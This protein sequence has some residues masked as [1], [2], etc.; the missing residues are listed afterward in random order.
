MRKAPL[1][2]WA[3]F[4][5]ANSAFPTII[6]TFVFATYFSE[7]VAINKI[8]GSSQWGKA[9]GIASLF[10]AILSPILGAIA[11]NEGRRKPWLAFFSLL[12]I[13]ATA[14]LWYAKPDP[15]YTHYTLLMVIL[16]TIGMEVGMVFYNA[17]L[18]ELVPDKYVG[19]ASGWSWGLGYFGGLSALVVAL[20][21]FIDHGAAWFG[22][23]SSQAEHIRICGPLVAA[24]FLIFGWP[25]FAF[26]PDRPSTGL[27]I[28]GA[29]RAGLKSLY[30]T[31]KS[32]KQ[33]KEIAKFLLARILY[34]DGL[35]TIFAFGGIYAAGTFNM[36][37][38]EVIEF[39]IAMN[40]GA[41]L[42]AMLFGWL[43]DY[44]GSKPTVLISLVLMMI[45]GSGMLLAT[46]KTTFWILGMILSLCVGP[47]QSASRSIM[48]HLAPPEL[49]TELFGLYAFSGKATA[50]MGPWIFGFMTLAFNSQRI[51]MSSTMLFLLVGAVI[52]CFVKVD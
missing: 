52:L 8:I 21:V 51:G 19:R 22:L 41:G 16:G 39:G 2:A 42:G 12:C 1:F 27:G 36:S 43:D 24:W 9:I 26:T 23:S 32:L 5:W 17:M 44:K 3:I 34:I 28:Q 25:L 11:D 48:V 46:S 18:K 13:V 20:V 50:F 35:N 40:V 30:T 33:Y 49:I 37:M 38:S 7:K 31:I 4:D 15:S 47:I 6:T 29:A 10:I 45:S 14:L